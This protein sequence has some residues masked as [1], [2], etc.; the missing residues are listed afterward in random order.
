[1][2]RGM[3]QISDSADRAIAAALRRQGDLITRPQVLAAG[4]TQA[5]LR[6]RT[7]TGGPWR[8][9]LPGIYLSHNGPLAVGQREVAAVLYCGNECVI[10]GQAALVR[11]GVQVPLTEIVDVLIPDSAKRQSAAFVRAHRTERMPVQPW[12]ADGIRWAPVARA[13]ADAV[14]GEPELRVVRALVAQAVQQGKCTVGQLAI[15]L[16]EGPNRGS[17]ALRATLDEVAEGVASAAE[18][19]LRQLIKNN[20]LPEPMYNPRLYVGSEFLAQPDAWWPDVGVAGE[21]DS[22]EWHLSPEQWA[23]TMARHARMTAR[24]IAVL[25]FTPRQLRYE[26]ARVAGELKSTIEIG[27]RHPAPAIRAVPHQQVR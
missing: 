13:V 21:V 15:E 22:R 16:R 5:A 4:W 9:V 2:L 6:Y 27:R 26:A 12:T 25:H 23:K 1:M 10:T 24:G 17:A 20:R 7:R 19:D 18:G 8:V 11:Q 3:R 14:R